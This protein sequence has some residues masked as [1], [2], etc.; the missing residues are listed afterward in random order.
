MKNHHITESTPRAKALRALFAFLLVALTVSGPAWVLADDG[1]V[2]GM[3]ADECQAPDGRHVAR[4]DCPGRE[5][6]VVI[7]P[8]GG[9]LERGTFL[10]AKGTPTNAGAF[11]C[12]VLS[13]KP[14]SVLVPEAYRSAF[15]GH[16]PRS[17]VDFLRE[18]RVAALIAGSVVVLLGF[19]F[20]RLIGALALGVLVAPL[21]CFDTVVLDCEGLIAPLHPAVL[22]GVLLCGFALG[23]ALGLQRC[24]LPGYLARG[25]ALIGLQ[26]PFASGAAATFGI[27]PGIAIGI[28]VLGTL[29][30]PVV[31]LWLLA[32]L[33]LTVGLA[34]DGLGAYIV[35]AAVALIVHHLVDGRW[36]ARRSRV[37]Q[38]RPDREPLTI[39][40]LIGG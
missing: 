36:V 10:L 28:S 6:R 33:L 8:G 39:L 40:D 32:S 19:V 30:S 15:E 23:V 25:I 35:A 3:V 2:V 20:L 14:A 11:P 16:S 18:H 7:L 27:A 4:V 9:Q 34:A 31:G 12:V 29:A 21:T 26:L 24:S 5:P 38:P 22:S 37:Q 17:L 1:Y 13:R